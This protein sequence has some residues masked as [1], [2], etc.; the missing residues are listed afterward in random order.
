MKNE[1]TVEEIT[2]ALKQAPPT[3]TAFVC[4]MCNEVHRDP[5]D[6]SDCCKCQDC[7]VKFPHESTY[8]ATCGHCSYGSRL[9]AARASVRS[10]EEQLKRNQ[11]RLAHLLKERRPAKGSAP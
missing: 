10:A 4:T 1:Q 7:G 2:A 5:R 11:D 6:A 3:V 8:G 9:R